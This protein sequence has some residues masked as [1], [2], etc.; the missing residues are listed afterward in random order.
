METDLLF[1]LK[2]QGYLSNNFFPF[3]DSLLSDLYIATCGWVATKAQHTRYQCQREGNKNKHKVL[4]CPVFL[5]FVIRLAT[6]CC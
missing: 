1:P 2:C 3:A 6:S 5:Y 4:N